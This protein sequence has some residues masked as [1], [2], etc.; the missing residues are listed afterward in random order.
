MH[1]IIN[2]GVCCLSFEGFI[3]IAYNY[4]EGR[5]EL[6]MWTVVLADQAFFG[7]M[8]QKSGF[9][10]AMALDVMKVLKTHYEGLA[11]VKKLKMPPNDTF[12][13]KEYKG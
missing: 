1:T 4:R 5:N 10:P 11:G 9:P 13:V 3:N 7:E 12:K 8:W 2:E 6:A